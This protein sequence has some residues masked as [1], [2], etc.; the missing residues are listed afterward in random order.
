MMVRESI[1]EYYPRPVEE[2]RHCVIVHY[3]DSSLTNSLYV[4]DCETH[5]EALA[6]AETHFFEKA[7]Y[8]KFLMRFISRIEVLPVNKELYSGAE[9]VISKSYPLQT[10]S[11]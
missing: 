4:I 2:T 11:A 1:P 8:S 3:H 7:H 9:P 10:V 6:K 5:S